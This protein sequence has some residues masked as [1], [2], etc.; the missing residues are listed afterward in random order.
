M[1]RAAAQNRDHWKHA[2][3]RL[4]YFAL[5]PVSTLDAG[6]LLMTRSGPSM[7]SQQ[8]FETG[9]WRVDVTTVSDPIAETTVVVKKRNK[10]A[11]NVNIKIGRPKLEKDETGE[12]VWLCH[13]HLDGIEDFVRPVQGV[14]SFHALTQAVASLYSM[15][16]IEDLGKARFSETGG[17]LGKE[18][19]PDPGVPMAQFFGF[20]VALD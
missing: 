14:S 4:L 10:S 18:I 9:V 12:S 2:D 8:Y 7:G 11:L 5:L 15:F 13:V 6:G 3:Q 17:A 20:D 19:W 16:H 1:A